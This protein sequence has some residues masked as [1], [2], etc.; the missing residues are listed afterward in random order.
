[1]LRFLL[2]FMFTATPSF[3]QVV[4]PS[5]VTPGPMALPER[6]SA[7]NDPPSQTFGQLFNTNLGDL[8]LGVV[9]TIVGQ[10]DVSTLVSRQLW[11]QIRIPTDGSSIA[12]DAC[13]SACWIHYGNYENG[14]IVSDK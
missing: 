8:P 13:Q 12:T 9:A 4:L 3:A 11:L 5:P 2:I 6:L 14:N 10:R 7:W 1:M